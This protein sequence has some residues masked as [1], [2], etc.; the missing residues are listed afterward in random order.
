M[1]ADTEVIGVLELQ[2]HAESFH[3][4]GAAVAMRTEKV[5]NRIT[6]VTDAKNSLVTCTIS[7]QETAIKDGW[8]S[9]ELE[10][11]DTING[12]QRTKEESDNND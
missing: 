7:G 10:E 8:D 5:E 12:K 4:K 11:E 2:K 1:G 9:D 6:E 3:A